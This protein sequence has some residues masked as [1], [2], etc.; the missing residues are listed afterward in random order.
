VRTKIIFITGGVLSSLGKGVAAAAIGALLEARGLRVTFQKLDPYIN[1]DPGTMNPF[2]HGEVFVTEDGA[3]TDLDLGHYERFTSVTLGQPH[4]YTSGRIYFNVITKERRGD[5]L[6]GTVQ[7]IPHITDE[8]KEAVLSV[9]SEADVAIIEIGGTVGDIESLPFLEA[10]RQL[11]GDLGKENVCYIHVTLVPY[12][13]TSGEVKTKP[14]QHSVKEL[15]SIGIQPDIILCRSDHR[16]TADIK[17]KIA[18]FCNVEPEFVITAQDVESIYEIP[19]RFHEEGLDERLIEVLNIWTGAPKLETWEQLVHHIKNP[20]NRVEIGIIGKYVNLQE[21]YKSMH[22]A[23]VHG[24]LVHQVKVALNYIDAEAVEREGPEALLSHLHGILVPGGFGIR[25]AEGKIIAIRYAR[26]NKIPYLGLCYGM[27]LA[28]VEFARHVA[29]M[30]QAQSEEFG[31][32]PCDPVIY[33]MRQW[34]DYRLNAVV[35]RDQDSDLGG[36]MRLGAYPCVLVEG[37]LAAKAYNGQEVFERH[38]HRYEFNNGYRERLV[39]AGLGITGTSP[40]GEL[41]EII[42]VPDHPWFLGCQF[43][44]EFKSRPLAPHPLFRDYVGACK[45]Y[46]STGTREGTEI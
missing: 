40:N 17:A 9:T 35:N 29:G 25:G 14:T 22:E 33:L 7:V 5:Y 36:T 45:E 32:T 21:S 30:S 31:I 15:R 11:K 8:I 10:I 6:G 42:E 20:T 43:H 34:Y 24:G 44:P 38:R 23:L 19:L 28:V 3:E 1:V 2:Q 41:V 46:K 18:L 37:S 16:L 13:K 12:I 26:E 27:Q 39:E 4:N